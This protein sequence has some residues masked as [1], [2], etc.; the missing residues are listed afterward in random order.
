MRISDWSSDV[1]S[2]ELASGLR[3]VPALDVARRA[4]RAGPRAQGGDEP[5]RP[6]APA[7]EVPAALPS[8]PGQAS[9]GDRKG[10][11]KGKRV[12]VSVDLGGGRILKKKQRTELHIHKTLRVTKAR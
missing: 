5:G 3:L 9:R 12:S 10:V 2:S 6:Q 1:C 4:A 8:R 11:V 7:D